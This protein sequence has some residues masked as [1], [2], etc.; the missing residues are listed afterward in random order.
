M[1]LYAVKI[2]WIAAGTDMCS[3]KFHNRHASALS[4]YV[5]EGSVQCTVCLVMLLVGGMRG[6]FRNLERIAGLRAYFRIE[7][8]LQN[9]DRVP[10]LRAY[11]G[12]LIACQLLHH[13]T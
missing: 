8:A 4:A 5:G 6:G 2:H 3:L 7:S 1:E 13:L 9:L 12:I 10:R 11:F